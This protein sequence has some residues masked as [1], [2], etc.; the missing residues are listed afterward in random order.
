MTPFPNP[1]AVLVSGGLD[2][3][4]LLAEV[5]RAGG[6]V[7]PLYVEVGSAWE[8]TEREYLTRFLAAMAAPNLR[9]LTVFREPI[10][11][12]Y[13]PH[14]SLTGVGVPGAD[15]PDSAVFLPGRNVLLLA[16]P[17]IWCHLYGIPALATAPLG[18][19][20]FPDATP[21]F[22][23]G[24]ASIVNWAVEGNVRVLRPYA[25]Q[26][27]HKF[28]VLKRGANLPL[29][30]TFSCIQPQRGLHCGACNKCAE[31][32]TGFREAE[33]PDPTEYANPR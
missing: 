26:G 14:W 30:L 28:N 31:R 19:N 12:V 27:L 5:V 9:P 10:A 21:E 8:P 13:G 7:H 4:I 6:T 23:E 22:Y 33:M 3:A 1:L 2:S 25:E 15:T 32:Q 11:E 20:P 29:K 17:L 16:K 24:F 18:S